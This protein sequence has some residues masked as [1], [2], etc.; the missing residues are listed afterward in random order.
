MTPRQARTQAEMLIQR[1]TGQV[2]GGRE[3]YRTA[4]MSGTMQL[5]IDVFGGANTDGHLRVHVFNVAPSVAA[6]V[7]RRGAPNVPGL[8]GGACRKCAGAPN[9]YP[10]GYP[11]AGRGKD[12]RYFGF[13]WHDGDEVTERD[14]VLM[15]RAVA[16]LLQH[17]PS[18]VTDG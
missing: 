6:A 4:T 5:A 2:A 13:Q 15:D 8:R 3:Y 17:F 18:A 7:V 12:R 9:A 16:W 14:L 1:R 11:G 10:A